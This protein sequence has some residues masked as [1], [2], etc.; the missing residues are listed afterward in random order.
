MPADKPNASEETP[1]QRRARHTREGVE[2]VA[3]HAAKARALD[4]KTARLK[5]HRLARTPRNDG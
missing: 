2:A 3:E 1:I 4:D 5:A